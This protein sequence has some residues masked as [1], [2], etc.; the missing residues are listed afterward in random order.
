M[1]GR[2]TISIDLDR[3]C[4]RAVEVARNGRS[5]KVNRMVVEPVPDDLKRD[6]PEVLGAWIGGR[7]KAARFPRDRATLAIAREHVALKRM[8]MPITTSG[9]S[10][11]SPAP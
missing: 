1:P 6:D 5:I 3:H 10:L 11:R 2:G 4:L 9:T 7:L 8:A